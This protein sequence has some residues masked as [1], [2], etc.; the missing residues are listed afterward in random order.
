MILNIETYVN[1]VLRVFP[2]DRGADSQL[3]FLLKQYPLSA[4]LMRL[5][6]Y[7]HSIILQD[8]LV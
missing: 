6:V 7:V 5:L 2:L 3:C 1:D 4:V 8:C